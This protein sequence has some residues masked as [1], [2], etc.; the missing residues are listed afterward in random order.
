MTS[1]W[2][3]G[4][5]GWV[6]DSGWEDAGGGWEAAGGGWAGVRLGVVLG[7]AGAGG[8]GG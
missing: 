5:E 3:A 6:G 2:I 7:A 1:R 8:W 4:A